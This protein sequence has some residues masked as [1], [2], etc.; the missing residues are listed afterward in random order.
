MVVTQ[1]STS[2][3]GTQWISDDY[4][5]LTA[6]GLTAAT[7]VRG[8]KNH[9]FQVTLANKNTNVIVGISGSTDGTSFGEV[10]LDFTAVTGGAITANRITLTV[11]GTY[12]ITVKNTPLHSVKFNFISEAGGATATLDVVYYGQS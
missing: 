1:G 7:R 2:T 8:M 3:S 11:D 5:Q 6:V 9:T 10:P 12:L 4:T